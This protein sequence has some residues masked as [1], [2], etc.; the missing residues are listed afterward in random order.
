MPIHN[1]QYQEAG[2]GQEFRPG[3]K[4][5]ATIGPLLQIEVHVPTTL[6]AQIRSADET[7]PLPEIGFALIDTGAAFS[8][9][10]QP[11]LEKLGLNPIGQVQIGTAGGPQQRLIYTAG[12]EFPGSP[13]PR[14][15][16]ARL[17]GVDLSSQFIGGDPTKPIVAL[18]GREFSRILCSST[19][20]RVG[21]SRSLSSQS[22]A[23]QN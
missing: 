13:L 5:L 21:L 15:N 11:V 7:V 12:F 4:A 22:L 17:V 10:D 23:T 16:F 14:M 6:A 20:A 3:L 18:I 1:N 19:M 2:P 8:C 9:V